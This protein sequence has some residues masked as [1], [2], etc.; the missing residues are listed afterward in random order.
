[1]S[2]NLTRDARRLKIAESSVFLSIR[3][4]DNSEKLEN[5]AIVDVNWAFQDE[6]FA[7]SV[8]AIVKSVLK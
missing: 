7:S 1:M 3:F 8:I 2:V 4:L 5:N 6:E